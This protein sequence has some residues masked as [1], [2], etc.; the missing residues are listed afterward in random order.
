MGGAAYYAAACAALEATCEQHSFCKRAGGSAPTAAPPA[1]ACVSNDPNID[2]SA[3]CKA[4]EAT[5][6]QFSFCTRAPSFIQSS[7]HQSVPRVVRRLRWTRRS[8]HHVLL[9][10]ESMMQRGTNVDE[11]ESDGIDDADEDAHHFDVE[12]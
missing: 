7:A 12:L 10:Q 1:G 11:E 8:T 6:E 3:A 5:C 4:L 2:F 9:Q